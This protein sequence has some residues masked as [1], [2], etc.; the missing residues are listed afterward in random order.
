M[1]SMDFRAM[2]EARKKPLL[3]EHELLNEAFSM[4]IVQ[5]AMS[6]LVVDAAKS[7]GKIDLLKKIKED[8]SGFKNVQEVVQYL[9]EAIQYF[10]DRLSK[11]L[12][13][14][15]PFHIFKEEIYESVARRE[16]M[17]VVYKEYSPLRTNLWG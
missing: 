13:A 3:S 6:V 12:N 4:D 7:G 5:K 8:V 14:M 15:E 16:G 10:Q 1:P 2:E 9:D 11:D 17:P